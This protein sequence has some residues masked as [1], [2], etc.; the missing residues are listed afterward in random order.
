MLHFIATLVNILTYYLTIC[1]T[2][3]VPVGPGYYNLEKVLATGKVN[4]LSSTSNL[5]RKPVGNFDSYR[6]AM[7]KSNFARTRSSFNL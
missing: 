4:V 5:H 3:T 1:M 2:V 6:R 7:T